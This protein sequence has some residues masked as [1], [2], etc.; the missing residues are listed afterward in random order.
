MTA[1]P[2]VSESAV[3][4]FPH[5]IKGSGIYLFI[6]L[7]EGEK[8]SNQLTKDLKQWARQKIGPIAAP[9][10]IQWTEG[11]PKTRSGKVMRRILRQIAANQPN[12]LGDTSTLSDPDVV[13]DLIKHRLNR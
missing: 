9:D 10:F 2:K 5:K 4:A 6:V 12:D 13:E 1:H 3:V 8:P 11:L 7:A